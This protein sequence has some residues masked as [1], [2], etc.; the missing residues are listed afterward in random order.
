MK[1]DYYIIQW[2]NKTVICYNGHLLFQFNNY[3]QAV[4]FKNEFCDIMA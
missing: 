1:F 4:I 3:K 2:K